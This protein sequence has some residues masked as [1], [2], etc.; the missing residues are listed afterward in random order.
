MCRQNFTEIDERQIS[1]ILQSRASQNTDK[2]RNQTNHFLIKEKNRYRIGK[3]PKTRTKISPTEIKNLLAS[4]SITNS[5]EYRKHI[6]FS[7]PIRLF[8]V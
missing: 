3:R 5:N 6:S 1:H 4:V 2:T 7:S 8:T